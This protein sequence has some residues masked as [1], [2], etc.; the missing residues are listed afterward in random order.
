[1]NAIASKTANIYYYVE[2]L[3][4]YFVSDKTLPPQEKKE[5]LK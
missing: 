1:M 3:N 4:N 2:H 5:T